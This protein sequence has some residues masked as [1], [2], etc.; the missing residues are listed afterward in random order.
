MFWAKI[1][2]GILGNLAFCFS[3]PEFKRRGVTALVYKEILKEEL[4]G[5]MDPNTSFIQ[6]NAAI[7]TLRLLKE[8]L[9]EQGFKVLK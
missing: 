9:S 4:S 1:R 3:N 6:D 7:H 5:L 8:W 2:Y